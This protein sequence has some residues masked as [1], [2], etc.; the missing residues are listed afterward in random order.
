[1]QWGLRTLG[2]QLCTVHSCLL[3]AESNLWSWF[4]DLAEVH[5]N[6]GFCGTMSLLS[7]I[8]AYKG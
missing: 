4:R 2:C 5:E 6:T 8:S 1:R 3:S 7:A